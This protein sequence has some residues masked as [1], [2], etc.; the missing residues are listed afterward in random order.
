MRDV[1]HASPPWLTPLREEQTNAAQRSTHTH[2]SNSLIPGHIPTLSFL[3]SS[4]V[5]VVRV[6][7]LV[8]LPQSWAELTNQGVSGHTS[9]TYPQIVLALQL[10]SYQEMHLRLAKKEWNNKNAMWAYLLTYPQ[11]FSEQLSYL[12]ESLMYVERR[13]TYLT[14]TLNT[15]RILLH[16]T[17]M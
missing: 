5:G 11:F 13:W 17:M 2:N 10:K 7:Q 4:L 8:E 16:F 3:T 15:P 14:H 9:L 12:T 6:E 1:S